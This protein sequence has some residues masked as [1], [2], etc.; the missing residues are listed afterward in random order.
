[1]DLMQFYDEQVIYCF[2]YYK[3]RDS[4]LFWAMSIT[5]TD[6]L[7]IVLVQAEG[8]AIE[9]ALKIFESHP[10][11]TIKVIIHTEFLTQV[12][13]ISLRLILPAILPFAL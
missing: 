13:L 12:P 6:L 9:V 4:M 10:E 2:V 1:M 3:L 7:I 5:K 11:N 8:C